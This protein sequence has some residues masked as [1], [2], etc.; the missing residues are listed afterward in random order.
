VLDLGFVDRQD[1]YDAHA[2]A[3]VFAAVADGASR[4]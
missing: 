1:K 3:D 4:S 2:A